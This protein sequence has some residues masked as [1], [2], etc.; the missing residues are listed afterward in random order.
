MF[1]MVC[2]QDKRN[3]RNI[4]VFGYATIAVTISTLVTRSL[5]GFQGAICVAMLVAL[6]LESNGIRLIDT[7]AVFIMHLG[8]A[9]TCDLLLPMIKGISH[10]DSAHCYGYPTLVLLVFCT[11]SL[12]Q[13]SSTALLSDVRLGSLAGIT[14]QSKSL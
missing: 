12:L 13:L 5:I 6:S 14:I 2:T 4:I 11:S 8:M 1:S 3:W 7:P 10:T 9:S